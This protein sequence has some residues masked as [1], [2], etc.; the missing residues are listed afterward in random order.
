MKNLISCLL[1]TSLVIFGACSSENAVITNPETFKSP[2]MEAFAKAFKNLNRP[3]NKPTAEEKRSGSAELSD[4]RKETLIPASLEL[5]KS[6]GVTDQEIEQKT[7]GD[8]S[9][10]IVWAIQIN[11]HKNNEIKNRLHTEN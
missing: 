5:I 2:E 10:I 9:A 1:L 4:R 3:E 7:K 8:M 11:N 6:T